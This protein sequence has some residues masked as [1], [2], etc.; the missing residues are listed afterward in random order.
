M[1]L[2]FIAAGMPF[3]G[4]SLPSFRTFT[5][6]KAK[7]L[8]IPYFVFFLV[9]VFIGEIYSHLFNGHLVEPHLFWIKAFLLNDS[10][11]PLIDKSG[12]HVSPLWFLHTLF[13]ALI[14]FRFA[15]K[16]KK[17]VLYALTVLF[18]ALAVLFHYIYPG[19]VSSPFNVKAIPLSVF[20]ICV[21]YLYYEYT[22]KLTNGKKA[23]IA[24]VSILIPIAYLYMYG[25]L[26]SYRNMRTL[27]YIPLSI[28]SVIGW[29]EIFALIKRN[30]VLE[31]L[32][33][34]SLFIFALHWALFPFIEK[35]SIHFG[36][37]IHTTAYGV[38]A[39]II[40]I[41]LCCLCFEAYSRIKFKLVGR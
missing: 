15:A 17:T 10:D 27:L 31:Y 7:S 29:Y 37:N 18:A 13:F 39:T 26:G 6:K 33:R 4:K 19:M 12:I 35:A 22:L 14:I 16:A 1:P 23:F 36:A 20:Y 40:N 11:M 5:A 38:F 21:G 28:L 32:G 3:F 30:A 34:V 25:R 2:F 8:L 41:F 24:I 9:A